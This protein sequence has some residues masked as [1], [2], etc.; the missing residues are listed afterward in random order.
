MSFLNGLHRVF[1]T[2]SFRRN[3]ARMWA[4]HFF[5]GEK[6]EVAKLVVYALASEL[7]VGFEQL[8]PNT[9]IVVDLGANEWDEWA[10]IQMCLEEDL[11]Y[12]FPLGPGFSG[13]T[14][15][16]LI[17]FIFHNRSKCLLEKRKRG[18]FE[19]A[20]WCLAACLSNEH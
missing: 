12:Y 7:G 9:N 20:D 2:E 18:V 10:G 8:K 15:K 6:E 11:K 3:Q 13:R 1:E 5:S 17:D 14:I 4:C 16:E 19:A